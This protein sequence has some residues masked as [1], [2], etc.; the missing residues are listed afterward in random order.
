[1]KQSCRLH[2]KGVL[3]SVYKQNSLKIKV[4]FLCFDYLVATS[5]SKIMHSIQVSVILIIRLQ[6]QKIKK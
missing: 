2:D 3:C 1:M 6:K 5:W 4:A